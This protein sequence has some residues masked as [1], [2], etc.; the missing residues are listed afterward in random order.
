MEPLFENHLTVEK[1]VLLEWYKKEFYRDNPFFV[2]VH[3]GLIVVYLALAGVVLMGR[4]LL[5][6]WLAV[7]SVAL[8]IVLAAGFLANLL[9]RYRIQVRQLLKSEEG[10][11]FPAHLGMVYYADFAM[12]AGETPGQDPAGQML[13]CVSRAAALQQEFNGMMS[14]LSGWTAE[15]GEGMDRLRPRLA[16]LQKQLEELSAEA[17]D[18]GGQQHN[19]GALTDYAQTPNLHILHFG[20]TAVLAAK[21]GFTLGEDEAFGDFMAARLRAVAAAAQDE[22][23]RKNWKRRWGN[24]LPEG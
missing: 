19:Y 7:A 9:L 2:G 22:K 13:A 23:L 1:N 3:A 14:Q 8:F 17:R 15:D 20:D 12:P 24:T 5:P 18:I 16:L 21:N 11:R 4:A 6:T 10:K